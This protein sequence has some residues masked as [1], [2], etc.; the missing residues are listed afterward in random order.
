MGHALRITLARTRADWPLLSIVAVLALIAT[1]LLVLAPIASTALADATVERRIAGAPPDVG[2]VSVTGQI[3]VT[4]ADDVVGQLA[5]RSGIALDTFW[6]ASS[7]GTVFDELDRE[8]IV[9]SL[10]AV[11]DLGPLIDWSEGGPPNEGETALHAD[12]AAFLDVRVGQTITTSLVPDGLVLAG[13]YQPR[14]RTDRRWFDQPSVRDGVVPGVNFTAIGPLVVTPAT[15]A[16][17]ED[18]ASIAF[19]LLPATDGLTVGDLEVLRAA[20]SRVAAAA[21]N[22]PR[23]SS[24]R[25][26]SGLDGLVDDVRRSLEGARTVVVALLLMVSALAVPALSIAG[27]LLGDTRRV[28]STLL[29]SRGASRRQIL[30]AAGMESVLVAAIVAALAL[31]TASAVLWL[32]KRAGIDPGLGIEPTVDRLALL[33]LT[34]GIVLTVAALLVPQ[35]RATGDT[36]ARANRARDQHVSFL[37]RTRLD[38]VLVALAAVG[39]WRVATQDAGTSSSDGIDPSII[40]G[41]AFALAGAAFVALR[42]IGATGRVL[43]TVTARRP[44]LIGALVTR[45]VT[46]RPTSV[47]RSALLVLL[48]VAIGSFALIH[49]A[50]WSASLSDQ[51]DA[52]VGSDVR[53]AIDLRSGR[54]PDQLVIPL[55]QSFTGVEG[56]ELTALASATLGD[57]PVDLVLRPSGVLDPV[58][59]R[60][61]A[62]AEAITVQATSTWRGD[63]APGELTVGLTVLDADGLVF[64]L[65]PVRFSAGSSQTLSF[66]LAQTHDGIET[67]L[68]Y[69]G[70]I[71]IL[72]LVVSAPA[73]L[74]ASSPSETDRET[75]ATLTLTDWR[76]DD[77]PLD[78]GVGAFRGHTGS[79]SFVTIDQ[80]EVTAVPAGHRIELQPGLAR[81][82]NASSDFRFPVGEPA[83]DPVPVRISASLAEQGIGIGDEFDLQVARATIPVIVA[84]IESSVPLLSRSDGAVAADLGAIS[85]AAVARGQPAPNPTDLLLEVARGDADE[86]VNQLT[87]ATVRSPNAIDR[88]SRAAALRNDPAQISIAVA[89][90][91]ALLGACAA[92]TVGLVANAVNDR[93]Q[94]AGDISILRALGVSNSSLRRMLTGEALIVLGVAIAL[95][96]SIA[97]IMGR[98]MLSSLAV[99]VD[100]RTVVPTPTV[101]IPWL[102]LG[103]LWLAVS[104]VTLLVPQLVFR[105][106]ERIDTA[107]ALR[108]GEGR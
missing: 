13:I 2:A 99:D 47:G 101:E 12:A 69:R 81:S 62:A 106:L 73:G 92:A 3:D 39:T 80:A 89:L 46:R 63:G 97:V 50:T 48:A 95:G 21:Q 82:L 4:N 35:A 79:R 29:A 27:G 77:E 44:T 70:P 108:S 72:E 1:T 34:L 26:E 86:I 22:E 74:A 56:A 38:L 8:N 55:V 107:T 6:I 54:L 5:E 28:E 94:R 85:T 52:E 65:P 68:P 25:T 61:S 64:E 10:V 104:T 14:D 96:G 37:R 16:L 59:T 7:S 43:D 103:L 24:S 102:A 71:Q 40:A 53:A 42:A 41:P 98:L 58:G 75:A 88:W 105:S 11:S 87:G 100:G 57:R 67:A 90:S 23:L 32:V 91:I 83:T 19:R 18:A 66:A 20:P 76:S 49:R 93:R 30:F 31:P 84:G 33:A 17:V 45:S 51:A 9:T 36:N 60:P 15:L 78:L